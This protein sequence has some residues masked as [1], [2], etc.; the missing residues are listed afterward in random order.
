MTTPQ[1]PAPATAAEA[2]AALDHANQ[3]ARAA[4]IAVL[5]AIVHAA[6]LHG[7]DQDAV[8]AGVERMVE[9]G[10]DG[11]PAVGE[12]LALEV[13]GILAIS[14]GAAIQRIGDALDLRHRHPKLW[15]VTMA[16]RVLV[17]Q[18]LAICRQAAYLSAEA[19]QKL[20]A[21]VAHGLA[22]MPWGRIMK[23]LPGWITAAD[24]P[25]AKKRAELVASERR[26]CVSPIVDGHVTLWGLLDPADGVALD[27]ALTQ[28]AGT[29]PARPGADDLQARRAAAVGVL[30]RQAFGQDALPTHTLVVHINAAEF[31]LKLGHHHAAVDSPDAANVRHVRAVL[32]G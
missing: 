4:E 19:V 21:M 30:A 24:I 17:W 28:I 20:D 18:A 16:G 26:V 13:G 27:H 10:H 3:T 12:F 31:A 7:V 1:V 29:L 11:T 5:L 14:P 23:A 25:A 32:L 6:D 9:P 15:D 22:T 8:L 2:F